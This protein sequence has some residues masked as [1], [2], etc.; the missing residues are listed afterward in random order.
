M[1]NITNSGRHLMIACI[2]IFFQTVFFALADEFV[3]ESASIGLK[4][5]DL[6]LLKE[7]KIKFLQQQYLEAL[8]LFETISEKEQVYLNYLKGICYSYDP[9][10]KQKALLFLPALKD[11]EAEISGYNF[12]MAYALVKNDSIRPAIEQYKKAL[13]IEEKKGL[14]NDLLVN[15]IN[16]SLQ[17]CYNNLI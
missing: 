2:L 14:K 3:F 15:E 8:D 5:I 4:G 16:L 10:N 12:N 6:K 9:D 17:H 13:A 11:K 7:G 1:T